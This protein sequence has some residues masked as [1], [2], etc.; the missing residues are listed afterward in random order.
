MHTSFVRMKYFKREVYSS[1][2]VA[3]QVSHKVNDSFP[4]TTLVC[5]FL[6]NLPQ[7]FLENKDMQKISQS[8]QF[9]KKPSSPGAPSLSGLR[10]SIKVSYSEIS[11]ICLF[12][13]E[14]F[15]QP[16][17]LNHSHQTIYLKFNIETH[18]FESC[19]IF[20]SPPLKLNIYERVSYQQMLVFYNSLF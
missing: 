8:F 10:D 13:F 20:N 15:L 14:Q 7:A 2:Q 17:K 4:S 18:C 6:P 3:F 9:L 5:V 11:L 16:R 19:F 1:L 12:L